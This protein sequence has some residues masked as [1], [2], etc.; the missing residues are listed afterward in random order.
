MTIRVLP[1]HVALKIAAGEVVDRPVSVVRELVDNSL[2]AHA[3]EIVV[4]TQN[5]G[6]DLIQ[7]SD[8]G[9]GIKSSEIELALERNATSKIEDIE[10]LYRLTSRGF[11]G[12]ALAS[13]VAVSRVIIETRHNTA[14]Q[15]AKALVDCGYLRD[16]SPV[17]CNQ[18][19]SIQVRQLFFGVPARRKFLKSNRIENE[20]VLSWLLGTAVSVPQVQITW[21]LDG[22][23]GKLS[24]VAS[25][26]ERLFQL[27]SGSLCEFD[28]AANNMGAR[29]LIGH[30]ASSSGKFEERFYILIN[31]RLVRDNKISR[32]VC[33]VFGNMLREAERPLGG[34]LIE[35]PPD[36]VDFNFH[37]Q[38]Q[39]VKINEAIGLFTFL[40]EG[41]KDALAQ[42]RG[43]TNFGKSKFVMGPSSQDSATRA[44]S[45]D[46]AGPTSH[47]KLR[48]VSEPSNSLLARDRDV[49]NRQLPLVVNSPAT[50][51]G[52]DAN[53]LNR[54][55][56]WEVKLANQRPVSIASNQV[57]TEG[58]YV[59][60]EIPSKREEFRYLGVFWGIFAVISFEDRLRLLDIHAAHER[61]NFYHLK[62]Q[63]LTSAHRTP[64]LI[65]LELSLSARQQ[66][67]L[68]DLTEELKEYGFGFEFSQG[69]A[70]LQAVPDF[71]IERLGLIDEIL[72]EII[73]EDRLEV[74]DNKLDD[75]C[76]KLACHKSVRRGEVN[77]SEIEVRDLIKQ[78]QEVDIGVWCPHGRPIWKDLSK[79]DVYGFF[80]RDR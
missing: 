68:S 61:I 4:V 44:Q 51:V 76:A 1:P 79:K 26:T 56:S 47:E 71:L 27:F 46:N 2:D 35:L 69:G 59:D 43:D 6:R 40:Q 24:Q 21:D 20:R 33:S 58:A 80:A 16:V 77:F 29:G 48:L 53:S 9:T 12:E 34:L 3:T 54:V 57:R 25:S 38:K 75:L 36:E 23:K 65:P 30:P 62:K 64:L 28:F 15:G 8:N 73:N 66:D 63:F 18:G 55:A 13:I 39:E 60:V 19:T 67:V 5:G 45:K 11:R 22:N 10:D 31:G 41:L 52:A 7:V 14:S 17:P 37:P 78:L 49:T 72:I 50:D 32:I 74:V 70:R 42:F